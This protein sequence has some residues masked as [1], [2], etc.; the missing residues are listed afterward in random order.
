VDGVMVDVASIRILRG[1][2]EKAER[3]GM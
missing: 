2:I 1:L 3:M